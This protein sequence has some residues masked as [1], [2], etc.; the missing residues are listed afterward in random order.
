MLVAKSKD[1]DKQ[2]FKCRTC[3]KEISLNDI[4]IHLG[5]CKEQQSYYEKM[6][7]FKIKLKHYVT[8]LV[9]YLAKLNINIT[10]I[11]RKIFG[12][13]GF[14]YKVIKLIPGCENDKDGIYFI[15]NL[16]KLYTFESRK[17]VNYYENNPDKIPYVISMSYFSLIIFLINKE[18]NDAEQEL[19]EIL[20]GIFC[21]LLQIMMNS[22]FLLYTKKCKTKNSIIKNKRDLFMSQNMDKNFLIN[23]PTLY[24]YMLFSFSG[25]NIGLL[26]LFKKSENKYVLKISL[27]KLSILHIV[28]I[29]NLC[30]RLLS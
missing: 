30:M 4:F 3:E 11:N 2:E 29:K 19:T 17:P 9:F 15:K 28:L 24:S 26:I 6:K 5:C 27:V 13:G 7:G 14:L 20:G 23:I 22:Q 16:I 12:K 25:Y 10:P 18:S 21:T 8:N 1:A